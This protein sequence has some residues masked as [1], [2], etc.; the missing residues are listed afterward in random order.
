ML[1][2]LHAENLQYAS[3]ASRVTCGGQVCNA[4]AEKVSKER[5]GTELKSMMSG[6]L[7][8][9]SLGMMPHV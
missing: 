3:Q 9:C 8:F 5:V 4:L 6:Q 2:I 1:A 7:K